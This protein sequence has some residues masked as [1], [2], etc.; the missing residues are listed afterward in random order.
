MKLGK[1]EI[2]IISFCILIFLICTVCIV[3][4]F[5]KNEMKFGHGEIG[6]PYKYITSTAEYNV[7][8]VE[9]ITLSNDNVIIE[10]TA[11]KNTF[12]D[13]LSTNGFSLVGKDKRP[14]E[15][16]LLSVSDLENGN[17]NI[18]IVT[19]ILENKEVDG[20]VF[21]RLNNKKYTKFNLR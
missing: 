19:R 16:E 21:T 20:V 15:A 14:V 8:V 4:I 18:Q 17:G 10:I 13:F 12:I 9:N 2:Y 7:M 1:K 3:S 6:A 11:D 5:K